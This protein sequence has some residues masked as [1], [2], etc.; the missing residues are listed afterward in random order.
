M[1]VGRIVTEDYAVHITQESNNWLKYKVYPI[2][3]N[4]DEILYRDLSNQDYI[5]FEEEKIY[6]KMEGSLCWRGVWEDR[7]YMVDEEYWYGELKELSD[8]YSDYIE[9]FCKDWLRK[10]DST[11]RE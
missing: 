11:I 2:V 10:L 1:V 3:V 8:L 6:I 5:E 9:P 7:Y 4:K